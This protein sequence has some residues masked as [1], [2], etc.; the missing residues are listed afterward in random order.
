ML[1]NYEHQAPVFDTLNK[2]RSDIDAPAGT[3]DSSGTDGPACADNPEAS[4][5]EM[6]TRCL[7]GLSF[8]YRQKMKILDGENNS[9][10]E[11]NSFYETDYNDR[12][13]RKYAQA[14]QLTVYSHANILY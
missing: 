14:G 7:L 2:L 10:L 12:S 6:S 4:D 11:D 9:N 8:I 1:P 5:G 3:D 13:F